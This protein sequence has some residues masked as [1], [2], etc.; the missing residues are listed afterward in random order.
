MLAEYIYHGTYRARGEKI[1]KERRMEASIGDSHWLGD[2]SYFFVEDFFAYKWIIDMYRSHYK[3]DCEDDSLL[4]NYLII[5]ARL[6][7][8]V[9]VFDLINAKHKIEFDTVFAELAKKKELIPRFQNV[10]IADGVVI[11]YMFNELGYESEFDLVRAVFIINQRHYKHVNSRLG[12]IPQEQICIKNLEVVQDAIEYNYTGKT[13]EYKDLIKNMYFGNVLSE[14]K[15][16]HNVKYL[17]RKKSR[18]KKIRI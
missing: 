12:F 13:S 3:K 4:E 5:S 2:G 6:K 11:N 15:A 10:E 7:E 14:K 9:R 18:Y 17:P 8:N 1:L 16:L